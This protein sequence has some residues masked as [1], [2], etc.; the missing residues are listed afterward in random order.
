MTAPESPFTPEVVAQVMHHMNV[1]HADDS[2]LICRVH[3]GQP[4]AEAAE[5]SGM[6]ADE[7]TFRATVNGSAIEVRIPWSRHLTERAQVRQ[8]V[9]RLYQEACAA[10]G[11]TPRGE[12]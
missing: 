11:L 5:M 12:G 2:L 1:D 7:I 4:T 6:D 10:L 9:V 8:E 3:G